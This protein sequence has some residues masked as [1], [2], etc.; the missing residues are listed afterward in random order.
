MSRWEASVDLGYTTFDCADIYT[1]VEEL[2]GTFLR[3]LANPQRVQIHTKYVPDRGELSRIDRAQVEGAIDR[4]LRRLGREAL[5]LVQFHWWD[6]ATAKYV[7]VAG[8]LHELRSA[9]KIRHLGLTNFDLQRS[10]EIV[11]AGVELTSVQVQYSVLDRRVEQGL[12]EWCGERRIALLCY[13]TLAGGLLT[14][15]WRRASEIP[16]GT[17]NRSLIKYGLIVEEFGGWAVFQEV[18]AALASVS[19]EASTATT[20]IRWALDRPEVA[21]CIVGVSHRDRSSANGL[22]WSDQWGQAD[23]SKL[24]ALLDRRPGPGGPVYALER[25]PAGPHM[26]IL[27]MNLNEEPEHE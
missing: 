25:D 24:T 5:D 9:G 11:E 16:V 26:K 21:G 12:R 27:R 20:A 1:G 17:L 7:E 4:S 15:A 22:L 8:W 6:Y 18:L 14:D 19:Q 2:L 13:G 10:R 23:W 3:R